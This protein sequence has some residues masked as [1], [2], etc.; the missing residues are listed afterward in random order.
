MNIERIV[1]IA[2]VA[3]GLLFTLL[4]QIDLAL[5]SLF[6]TPGRGFPANDSSWV[7]AIY[8]GVPIATRVLVV[9][10]AIGLIASLITSLVRRSAATRTRCVQ[11][12]FLLTAIALGP[13]FIIDAGLK[14]HWGRA[15]PAQVQE[16][17]GARRFTPALQPANECP[18]NCSFVSGHAAFGY[19][20][21]ALAYLGDARRRRR[22]LLIALLA[23][24]SLGLLRIAQGAHFLSDIVF[25]F[26]FT[27]LGSWTA[28][29]I[30]R[31]ALVK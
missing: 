17:G 14:D 30:W 23:G 25:S 26:F 15:R 24:S 2:A 9:G 22:W 5:T 1:L 29:L 18:D 31:R 27:W 11:L 3:A 13:G 7:I 6:F 21:I 8:R 16:F 20:L 28:Y 12:A 10:L 4:P 19:Q